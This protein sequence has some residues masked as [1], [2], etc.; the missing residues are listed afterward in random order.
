ML[1]SSGNIFD[2]LEHGDSIRTP[3]TR[4]FDNIPANPPLGM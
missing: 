4:K 3:I 2:E 1:I